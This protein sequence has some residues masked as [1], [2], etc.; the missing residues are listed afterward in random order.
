MTTLVWKGEQLRDPN[1][2]K[3]GSN[4]RTKMYHR[5]KWNGGFYAAN[6]E[7][8]TVIT[9]FEEIEEAKCSRLPCK[10]CFPQGEPVMPSDEWD[11]P[12]SM[13]NM[14]T[15]PVENR[16]FVYRRR[17]VTT[18]VQFGPFTEAKA[19]ELLRYLL[20]PENE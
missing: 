6:C 7:P 19:S 5:I 11:G 20:N 17:E 15:P 2:R 9:N 8:G 14:Y 3:M 1:L 13:A 4:R 12:W 18:S 16:W 10:K